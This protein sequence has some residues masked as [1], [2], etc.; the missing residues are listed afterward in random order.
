MAANKRKV[1]NDPVYGFITIHSELLYDLIETP[2]F[3]RLRRIKQ[4]GLTHLVYPGAMHTRFAHAL[5]AYHLMQKAI[6]VL[7]SKGHSITSEEEDAACAAILLHDIGHGPFSH[8]LESTLIEGI[9]HEE[10]SLMLMKL[11]NEEFQ[12][13]LN[14][15]IE[16]FEDRYS[17]RFLHQLVS[18]QL[19]VDRLDYISRDSFFTGV[20]EGTIG[21]DRIIQM[22]DVHNNFLVIESKG[23]YSIEKFLVARRLMY[24]QVYLHKTSVAAETL[25]TKVLKRARQLALAGTDV[26][27]TPSLSVFL[28]T[29]QEQ[30]KDDFLKNC[31]TSFLALDDDDVTSTIKSWVDHR[32]II[33]SDLSSKLTKRQLPMVILQNEPYDLGIVNEIKLAV[34]E[35]YHL[36]EENVNYYFECGELVNTTYKIEDNSI[37][38]I[39]KSG[40]NVKIEDITEHVHMGYLVREEKKSYLYIPKEVRGIL[41]IAF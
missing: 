37:G 4:L 7:R 29:K 40:S 31:L 32:D 26:P 9:D 13:K 16:I 17:K 18:S 6:G 1:I 24:W 36:D 33:L 5:G 19:D 39:R 35:M 3:Q 30:P 11:L 23:L 38:I 15:A 34:K 25:L 27:C 20:T 14:L 8:A 2:V 28:K 41:N 12:G 22:L 21:W 10:I